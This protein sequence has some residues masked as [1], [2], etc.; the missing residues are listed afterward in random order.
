MIINGNH[1]FNFS[2]AEM[3]IIQLVLKGVQG[4]S[5]WLVSIIINNNNNNIK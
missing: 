4:C 5:Q 1:T 3:T 2:Y